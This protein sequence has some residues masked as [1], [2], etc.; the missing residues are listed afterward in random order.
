MRDIAIICG[1]TAAGKS[2]IAMAL[3]ERH[4]A[5]LISA[6][7]RQVYR[8]FD[9][10]TAKP[11]ESERHRIAHRG[12]D[13]VDPTVR[14]SAAEWAVSATDWIREAVA[15]DQPV[16]V[17]GGTG[18]YLRTLESPLFES[19][20]LDPESRTAVLAS[21]EAQTTDALRARCAVI[22]P[23]RALLGRT[24]LL[25]ALE[26]YELTGRPLSAWLTERA[27]ASEFRAHYLVVDPG[28]SLRDRI[29]ARVMQM[30]D[31][32][33]EQEVA[34]LMR[35]V[36]ADAPAWNACGYSLLRAAFTGEVTREHAVERT[37]IETRQYAKRQRTWFRH[38][39]PPD[40]V[41]RLD[42]GATDATDAALAWLDAVSL[43]EQT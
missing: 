18:F 7:S 42:P 1:P 19:P 41:T 11:S 14:Y 43:T 34:T 32:G 28:V 9:I 2:A 5:V 25:R 13:V 15:R 16:I 27:R 4:A 17:V 31:A 37:I 20:P 29:A 23:T 40:R 38:Q 6:D 22:D 33:W 21:L 30:L 3:A 24:Q 26:T 10:G 12:I 39:L 36:A 35:D 8:R